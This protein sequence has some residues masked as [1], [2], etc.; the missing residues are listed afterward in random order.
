MSRIHSGSGHPFQ[1]QV[2]GV[3]A[4]RPRGEIVACITEVK[5]TVGSVHAYAVGNSGSWSECG[6]F[7][8]EVFHGHGTGAG[9]YSVK[10]PVF[11]CL[12]VPDPFVFSPY[13]VKVTA[14]RQ[15]VFLGDGNVY[16]GVIDGVY[17]SYGDKI[18]I[19]GYYGKP[20][21]LA[22]NYGWTLD[23]TFGAAL[24]FKLGKKANLSV[25]YDK[26]KEDADADDVDIISANLYGK[27]TD[28]FGLGVLYMH[29]NTDNPA[30]IVD[31]ASK[32]GFVVTA[33]IAGASYAKP[34]SWGFSAKYYYAPA[35]SNLQHTMNGGASDGLHTQGYKGYSLSGSYTV[36]KNMMYTMQWFDLKGR[37]DGV[38]NKAWWNEFQVRF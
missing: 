1:A 18:N 14:G 15:D 34:G 21:D 27:L 31:G 28:K 22:D 2:L 23:E 5:V 25:A 10:F 9:V 19:S 32:N 37:E 6:S 12:R 33:D 26:F 17:A 35:G 11:L 16:D 20:T 8:G 13:D 36:A 4:Y 30:H 3:A 7:R 38:K 24:G 29:T